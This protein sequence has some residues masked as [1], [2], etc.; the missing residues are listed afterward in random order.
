MTNYK[1][2]GVMNMIG[3]KGG[4]LVQ[5]ELYGKVF[6]FINCHLAS[7]AHNQKERAQ[8][9]SQILRSI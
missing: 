4:V 1:T 6:S 9:I 8:M 2:L 3:N 5:F 7:G